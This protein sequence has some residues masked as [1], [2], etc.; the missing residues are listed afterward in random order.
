MRPWSRHFL[1]IVVSVAMACGQDPPTK[2]VRV[3]APAPTPAPKEPPKPIPGYWVSPTGSDEAGTGS[4]SQPWRTIERGLRALSSGDTLNLEAGRYRI[5]RLLIE[6]NRIKLVGHGRVVLDNLIDAFNRTDNDAWVIWD[7]DRGVY[8]SK[9]AFNVGERGRAWGSF[10]TGPDRRHKL[11]T[12]PCYGALASPH[13]TQYQDDPNTS[14]QEVCLHRPKRR[15]TCNLNGTY[16]PYV[17]PGIYWDRNGDVGPAGHLY[18]R[19]GANTPQFAAFNHKPSM[20]PADPNRIAMWIT[21][22]GAVL[23]IAPYTTHVSVENVRL[24]HGRASIGRET[25]HIRLSRVAFEGLAGRRHLR[26]RGAHIELD[27][28]WMSEYFPRWLTWDDAKRIY[29][30]TLMSSAITLQ[31]GVHHVFVRRSKIRRYHDGIV[32]AFDKIHHVGIHDSRFFDIQD[33]VLQLGSSA[34]D[35][36]VS[37]NRMIAVGTSVSQHGTGPNPKPGRKYIHH[38]VI[39]LRRRMFCRATSDPSRKFL[40]RHCDAQGRNANFAFGLHSADKVG[41]DGDPRYFYNNTVILDGKPAGMGPRGLNRARR[42]RGN[43]TLVLNNIFIQRDANAPILA[44]ADDWILDQPQSIVL[45]G[46]LFYRSGGAGSAFR[47]GQN[48]CGL[49]DLKAR[50][51]LGGTQQGANWLPEK[52]GLWLDPQLDRRY[53]PRAKTPKGSAP[54]DLG[55]VSRTLGRPLPGITSGY[56]GALAPRRSSK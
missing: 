23:Y 2:S 32:A 45:D 56:R 50:R 40:S 14:T 36:E 41:P 18:V 5:R 34:H 53:R 47:V 13:S 15:Y 4:R 35:V 20:F 52:R 38:N 6:H 28:L 33:D 21:I 19:M 54:V 16:C 55:R 22:G 42:P 29:P 17:G 31:A 10:S 24:R 1:F 25:H 30:S 44:I 51:C 9:R 7:R 26:I 11:V 39:E 43:P 46:N 27:R 12:Y 8:R 37:G 3:E 49:G 48:L